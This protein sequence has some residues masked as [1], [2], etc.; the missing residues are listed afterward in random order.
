MSDSIV[1]FIFALIAINNTIH[2]G[3]YITGAN[4]YDIKQMKRNR[5]P[6]LRARKK[7]PLVTVIVPAHNELIGIIRTLDS[8][9]RSTYRKLQ[10][11]VVDDASTDDTRKVA[12]KYIRDYPNRGIRL[13]RKQKNVGKGE[14]LNHVLRKYARGELVMTLDAD[15]VLDNKA[16]SNAVKYFDDPLVIGIAANVQVVDSHSVLGMLQKF[17]HLIGYRSKKFY[18]L[19]NSEFVIGGVASTYRMDV[20]KKARFYDTDTQTEDIGLSLKLISQGNIHQKIVYASDV[21]AMTEGVQSYRALFKQRY[22]WKLGML[23][24]LLKY[25]SIIGSTDKKYSRLLTFYRLPMSVLSEFIILL[26]PIL[27]AYVL[28]LSVINQQYAMF[29]GAYLVITLYT[30]WTVWPDEH[31]SNKSKFRMS[32]Y[33]PIMYF[34]FYIMNVVQIAALLRCFKNHEQLRLKV[35]TGGAWSSPE[36]AIAK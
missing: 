23:Q 13:L 4:I 31:L 5:L 19:T 24:N 15:S 18:T 21:L 34:L 1:L 26:E 10:I 35:A 33:S 30:L 32:M 27:L 3:A 8:I 25:R 20:I 28:Y 6:A 16:I 36:R 12:L 2:F 7:K 22:R 9:R 14:A 29:V 11:L 17:E